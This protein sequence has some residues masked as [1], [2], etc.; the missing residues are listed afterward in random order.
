[1]ESDGK[2]GYIVS[3]YLAG[4]IYRVSAAGKMETITTF[5]AGTADIGYDA[6]R[7]LLIVPH[8]NDDKITAYDMAVLK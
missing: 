3:D 1:L 8:M 6:G 4:K 2:G 5:A 7:N